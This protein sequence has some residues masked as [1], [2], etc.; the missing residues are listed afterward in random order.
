MKRPK[1][2]PSPAS[3]SV[4]IDFFK[5]QPVKRTTRRPESGAKIGPARPVSINSKKSLL[6]RDPSPNVMI[7]APVIHAALRFVHPVFSA[8]QATDG[9]RSETEDVIAAKNAKKKNAAPIAD[10]PGA[11]SYTHLTLPTICSV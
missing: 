5:R 4:K 7:A 8:T 2:S 3:S 6:K 1:A 10:P 9:S 11:V